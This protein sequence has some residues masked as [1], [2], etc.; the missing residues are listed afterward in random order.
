MPIN[1]DAP[2]FALCLAGP[3]GSGKTALAVK[4]GRMWNCEIINA[5]SRQAYADFPIITAQPAREEQGDL[6]HHLYGILPTRAKL[7]AA[8]WAKLAADKARAIAALGKT[9][10]FVGGSGFY[11][12][13]L[14]D[15]LSAMPE[16][17][18]EISHSIA[19]QMEESGPVA[20]HERLIK[21]D[22]P[23]AARIHPH[24]RIRIM[25]GLEVAA[26]TGKP[27][28]WWQKQPARPLCQGPRIFINVEL[29]SLA[30]LLKTRI[31]KMIQAGAAEEATRALRNCP[32]K[33]APGWSGIGCSEALALAEKAAPLEEIKERW[34]FA[35]RSYAKRQLTW[36][37]NKPH[38]LAY[39]GD[40]TLKMLERVLAKSAS[41]GH[42]QPC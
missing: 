38:Y 13:A 7:D 16:I 10:L 39:K 4:L 25:R 11:L 6:P 35:T 29:S 24:D 36:F 15:G 22:P 1:K 40:A 9:P 3:T 27:L 19:A 32:D 30:P 2:V 31:E 23:L 37:R 41:S 20:L 28:S 18:A 33:K 5:D 21:L 42:A 26:A 34:L 17:P 8:A 12:T 14:F